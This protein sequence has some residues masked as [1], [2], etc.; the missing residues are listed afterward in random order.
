M[1]VDHSAGVEE[2]DDAA[3][4]KAEE[5]QLVQEQEAWV[6]DVRL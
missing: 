3:Q 1:A 4:Q 5:E 6:C 2:Q